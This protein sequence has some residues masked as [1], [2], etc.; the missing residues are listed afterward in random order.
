MAVVVGLE[1]VVLVLLVFE[2]G[3][4][5]TLWLVVGETTGFVQAEMES[6][7]IAGFWNR[8]CLQKNLRRFYL[9]WPNSFRQ[10]C[11][12]EVTKLPYS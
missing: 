11:H 8:V 10:G 12:F 2:N 9:L 6:F 4:G 3:M 1:L 5:E 7:D